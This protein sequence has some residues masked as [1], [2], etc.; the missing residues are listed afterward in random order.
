[1]SYVDVTRDGYVATVTINRPD[2]LNALSPDVLGEL[3]EIAEALEHD[4]SVR[5]VVLTGAGR[6]F[7]AGADISHMVDFDGPA[8]L[9]FAEAGAR[10]L[11]AIESSRNPWIARV[12]GPALG[13]GS[14]I[15][16]ACDIVIAGESARFGQPEVTIGTMPGWGGSQRLPRRVGMGKALE[17]CLGG[18]AIDAV[19]AARIGL[20]EQVVSDE[21]LDGAVMA[22]AERIAANAPDA[23]ADTK[24]VLREGLDRPLAEGLAREREL[25]AATFTRGDTREG[26][27]AFLERPRR[28]PNFVRHTEA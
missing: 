26:M 20:V 18:H 22:L 4:D 15:C 14:E 1:M 5:V 12:N 27:G 11:D 7:A 6:A 8:A 9:A 10:F 23:V 17:L 24:R 19:E 2:R 21:E 25:F 3:S 16:A 13:G 28:T